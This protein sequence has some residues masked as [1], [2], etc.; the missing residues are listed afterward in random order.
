MLL[1]L[2]FFFV[3]DALTGAGRRRLCLLTRS[4]L[5]T[6]ALVVADASLR[7]LRLEAERPDDGFLR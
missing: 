4:A 2:C 3:P 7:L 1:V 5:F 6:S